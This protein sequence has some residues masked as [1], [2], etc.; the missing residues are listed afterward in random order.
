MAERKVGD[1]VRIIQA[2]WVQ[3][4]LQNV[5]GYIVELGEPRPHKGDRVYG[6]RINDPSR[7][8]VDGTTVYVSSNDVEA[9]A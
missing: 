4:K 6:I 7:P 9:G 2:P 5:P 3:A 1:R 8:S